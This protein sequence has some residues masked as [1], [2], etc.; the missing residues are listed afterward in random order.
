[1]S[2][3][4]ASQL[5]AARKDLKTAE[6]IRNPILL[7]LSHRLIPGNH[8][9]RRTLCPSQQSLAEV[10]T[11]LQNAFTNTLS[12]CRDSLSQSTL[13][14][15]GTVCRRRTGPKD[16]MSS[17]PKEANIQGL[18]IGLKFTSIFESI[19][20]LFRTSWRGVPIRMAFCKANDVKALG[21]RY[22]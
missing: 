21:G 5:M 18:T 20:T 4:L 9:L 17:Y 13:S 14:F 16:Q 19:N 2:K 22:S 11:V 6:V 3:C 15:R 8:I 12:M 7:L 1:V 10:A